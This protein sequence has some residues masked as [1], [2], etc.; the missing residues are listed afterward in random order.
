MTRKF[1]LSLELSH[2]FFIEAGLLNCFNCNQFRPEPG[3]ILTR[4][5]KEAGLPSANSGLQL[6]LE[7]A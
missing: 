3:T 2:L 1:S 5:Y 7:I 6:D 4:R